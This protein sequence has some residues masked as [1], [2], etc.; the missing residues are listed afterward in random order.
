MDIFYLF[1]LP[2]DD[3]RGD[4]ENIYIYIYMMSFTCRCWILVIISLWTAGVWCMQRAHNNINNNN[5]I[6][7]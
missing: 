1:K 4:P 7:E 3:V 5:I 2:I 6:H